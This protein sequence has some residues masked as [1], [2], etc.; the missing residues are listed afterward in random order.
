M[1]RKLDRQSSFDVLRILALFFVIIIHTH[2]GS[3]SDTTKSNWLEILVF[4]FGKLGVPIFVMVSGALLLPKQEQIKLFYKKRVH[5]ILLPW[6]TWSMVYFVYKLLSSGSHLSSPQIIKEYIVVFLSD[7]WFMPMIAGIYV[8]TPFLRKTCKDITMVK[9]LLL[10][11]FLLASLI[12]LLYLSPLFPG[13]SS[14]GILTLIISFSGYFILG[15]Y[16]KQY[17][18]NK[19][20]Y[21]MLVFA[22]FASTCFY[23]YSAH[24]F[25]DNPNLHFFAL[26]DYVSPSIVVGSTALYLL[27]HKSINTSVSV[28][29]SK[30]LA[31]LSSYTYGIFL[32]H[33][34]VS[35]LLYQYLS[36]SFFN[37]TDSVLIWLI[38]AVLVYSSSAALIALATK[39]AYIKKALT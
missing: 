27:I 38:R 7:F 5:K 8:L 35:K 34:L 3:I 19:I 6:I 32:C 37:D 1:V 24:V 15:W 39:V 9:I 16:S 30:V 23:M 11:W 17:G 29:S 2:L 12:P 31:V 14:A 21:P 20:Q 4:Y 36:S 28:T 18:I 33:V 25:L 22:L 26:Q 10:G 13:A